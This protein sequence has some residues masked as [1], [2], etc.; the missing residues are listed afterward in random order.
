MA[1]VIDDTYKKLS[2][3]PGAIAQIHL[4]D[5]CVCHMQT[6]SH[7]H[8]R[9][10]VH[11]RTHTHTHTHMHART[12]THT[13]THAR[14]HTHTHT[15][16][17]RLILSNLTHCRSRSMGASTTTSFLQGRGI[18]PW[19]SSLEARGPLPHWPCCSPYTGEGASIDP[20]QWNLL[21]K[22]TSGVAHLSTVERLS[23]LQ[24]WE[25]Y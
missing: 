10:H 17:Y 24:R 2:N 4:E 5:S 6:H 16:T 7:M 12:H 15:H 8:A 23:T 3:N 25:L 1:D 22:D 20:L 18:V 9:T 13:H 19:T 14:T 11:T 21:I